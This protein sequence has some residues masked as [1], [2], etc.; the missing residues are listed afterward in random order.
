MRLLFIGTP[1]VAAQYLNFIASIKEHQVAA[2]ITQPDKPAG[3][4][5]N[6]SMPPVKECAQ[7]L[8]LSPVLQPQ[9][10]TE[11]EFLNTISALKPDLGLVVAYGKILPQLFLDLPRLGVINVHFSLLPQ[12]RGASPVEHA[13]LQGHYHT[14]VTIF[15]LDTGMDTGPIITQKDAPIESGE[16]TP[17]LFKKLIPMG[18]QLLA[19]S[20]K[21]IANNEAPRI[22][23]NQAKAT[24][25]TKLTKEMGLINWNRPNLEIDRQIRAL[26]SWPTAWTYLDQ[27]P[28]Q[29]L[30]A[31]PQNRV[32]T[33]AFHPGGLTGTERGL[34][35]FVKCGIGE[36]LVEE[37]RP[38]GG[39]QMSAWS[40]LQGLP[41][42]HEQLIFRS[43]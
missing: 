30:K 24:L 25:A 12:L 18:Q 43:H 19:Q 9:R 1:S 20:L 29:I 40:F 38:W 13:L 36:L 4:G 32:S 27:R 37:L 14:G 23:Q 15:W 6:L 22:P 34:G 26:I 35:F 16:T 10:V 11:S 42:P 5:L 41:K 31:Q 33:T 8:G 39:R 28:I 2:I 21:L 17:S 7:H 3:R